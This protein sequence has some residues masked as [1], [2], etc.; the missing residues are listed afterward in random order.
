MWKI[1]WKTLD[2]LVKT[3]AIATC[4][5]LGMLYLYQNRL[6]YA[7][8]FP[9]DSRTNVP[10]PDEFGMQYESIHL[11]TK[12][13]IRLKCY[14]I[15]SDKPV[16]LL[17]LHANAGNLGHRLPIARVFRHAGMNVFMLSYRGY[18]QSEGTPNEQG[19][20][21]DVQA[22]YEFIKSHPEL[23]HTK[24]VVYG[25]S[26]GGAAAIY[27]ASHF[28]VDALV[29]ENTFTNL[30]NLIP[31]VMPVLKY[32]TW[33]CHQKWPSIDRIKLVSCPTLFLSGLKDELVPPS[34]MR[35]L[36][37]Q[38]NDAGKSKTRWESF[39]NGTHND[40]CIQDGYFECII[41]FVQEIL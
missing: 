19:L 41:R 12:D 11:T 10:K 17:Y 28:Q 26:I 6:I 20:M 29:V 39:Q 24:L 23:K 14:L 40:T 4:G 3:A 16:T 32:L 38:A 27:C 2:F 1:L 22:A 9:Q 5:L 33:L 37:K 35:A 21:L 34:H 36:Y 25:Q 8:E 30:P 15:G 18:G 7:S 13:K 31:S